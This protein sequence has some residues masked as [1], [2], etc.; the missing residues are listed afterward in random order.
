[1]VK[2]VDISEH[3]GNVNFEN[4]KKAGVEFVILRCGYGQDRTSQDD[5]W[6]KSNVEKCIKHNMPYGVYLYS[7]AN[8]TEKAKSEV[9][10]VLRLLNGSKVPYGVWYDIEDKIHPMDKKLLTDIVVT[11]CE[12]LERAGHYVGVYS[13]LH[14]FN[15]RFDSRIDQYDKWVA[16]WSNK[17]TY[18]KPYGIW[19]FT[20]EL[21][22][23]NKRFDGNYAYKDYPTLTGC[24]VT[25]PT[26]TIDELAIEVIAGT[27]GVGSERKR[28]ITTAGY[29]YEYVQE[30]VN[31]YYEVAKD[32]Y[33]GV[34]GN[35][36]TRKSKVTK[37][38]YDYKTIQTLVN[39]M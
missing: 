25:K 17:C 31:K 27:W 4:L 9:Q 18:S 34:Y 28:N 37:L 1:M 30:R 10:H 29:D 21:K 6:F 33:K 19:Q 22:I 12:E 15:T 3:N 35:G 11:F 2:G 32:C 39:E 20:D 24:K 13:S 26:K 23:G 38:G 5:K 8:N 36:N 16:Q 14:W 7:Y